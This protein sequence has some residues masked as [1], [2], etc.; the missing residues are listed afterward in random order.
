MTTN[1]DGYICSFSAYFDDVG[2]V[3]F[4][5]WRRVVGFGTKHRHYKLLGEI[6]YTPSSTGPVTV[7]RFN[8]HFNKSQLIHKN[9]LSHKYS[10]F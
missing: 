5:V 2:P 9:F 4:Q 3:R 8:N 7:K 1:F 10:D 6:E